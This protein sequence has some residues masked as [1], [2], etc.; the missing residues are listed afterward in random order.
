[1]VVDRIA[2]LSLQQP[3]GTATTFEVPQSPRTL[4][5]KGQLDQQNFEIIH[6]LQQKNQVQMRV[7]SAWLQ[8]GWT[9]VPLLDTHTA[10][11]PQPAPRASL[12][13]VSITLMS[14]F[15]QG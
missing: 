7:I 5:T 9:D 12:D 10:S 14:T 15:V 1:M 2:T 3:Q 4:L 8:T 11:A 6:T 13:I